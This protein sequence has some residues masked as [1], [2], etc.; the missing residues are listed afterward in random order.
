MIILIADKIT[1]GS[2]VVFQAK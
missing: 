1:V 2:A